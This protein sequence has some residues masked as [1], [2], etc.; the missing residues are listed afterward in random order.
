MN[1]LNLVFGVSPVDGI[2]VAREAEP[3]STLVAG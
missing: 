1:K 3:G 2:V